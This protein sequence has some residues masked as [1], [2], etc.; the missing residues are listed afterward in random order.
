MRNQPSL[1][2]NCRWL[3][4]WALLTV[5]ATLPL[6]TLGAEVTTKQVGMVDQEWPTYPWQLWL[7][8]WQEKGLGFLIE[9]GH[10]LAGYTVGFCA[11]VLTA[12]LWLGQPRR[13]L[14]WLG[15]AGL[16]GVV[17]QGV[18][19][20]LRVRLNAWWGPELAM[21]HGC[22]GPLVFALLVSLV[23][24]TS[25]GW[26]NPSLSDEVTE[27][28]PS[29]RRWSLI[30][31]GLVYLQLVL[32]AWLRH[33]APGWS[34]RGHF[35]M[36]FVVVAAVAWFGRGMLES[37]SVDRRLGTAFK[38]LVGLLVGQLLLGVEAWMIKFSSAGMVYPQ[39]FLAH[40]DLVR[41]AHALVGWMILAATVIVALQAHRRMALTTRLTPEPVHH[42]EGVA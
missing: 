35:L 15:V 3:H 27:G 14:S 41:T 11:I 37:T 29:L 33:K 20:G 6:L 22:F 12:G 4:Y 7:E 13:W 10:R 24:F 39:R 28:T 17:I 31:F 34:Q 9:H 40:E 30:V 25:R 42:L 32:G 19:G 2:E 38:F 23:L 18:L 16:A 21:I 5:C 8:S 36:A 1:T 26:T